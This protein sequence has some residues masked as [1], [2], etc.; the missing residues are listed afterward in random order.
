MMNDYDAVISTSVDEF[1]SQSDSLG[2]RNKKKFTK[3]NRKDVEKIENFLD[4]RNG[5]LSSDEYYIEKYDCDCGHIFTFYDFVF[6]AVVDAHH[7][8]SFILHTLVGKKLIINPPRKIRCSSCGKITDENVMYGMPAS[9][10]CTAPGRG[11]G[12]ASQ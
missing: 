2:F 3:S 4:V 12:L 1:K 10:L 6:T 11:P 7:S 9:Y 5:T 8:K